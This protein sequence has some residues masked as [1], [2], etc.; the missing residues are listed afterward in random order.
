M[1]VVVVGDIDPAAM[2]KRIQKYF[3]SIQG[4]QKPK[5][6]AQYSV[7]DHDETLVAIAKDKEFPF[8]NMSVMW[9]HQRAATLT[10]AD[11]RRDLTHSL[12]SAMINARMS[13]LVNSS[14]PPFLGGSAGYGGFLG[15]KDVYSVDV[16]PDPQ[17]PLEALKAALIENRRVQLHGFTEGEL[18][19]AKKELMARYE[20][21]YNE[22]KKMPSAS[23][24][25][26][27]VNHFLKGDIPVS[28]ADRFEMASKML[29][30][31]SLTEVNALTK[32]YIRDKS[33]I[34]VLQAPDKDGIT[35]PSK[36]D[37]LKILDETDGL[38]PE[39]YQDKEIA[40]TLIEKIPKAGK[41]TSSKEL[42]LLKATEMT[43]SNGAKVVL[44]QTDFKEDEIQVSAI[45]R[46]GHS[47]YADKDYYSASWAD[48][49]I[50]NAGLGTLS[51]PDL[52]KFLSG[53]ILEGSP[54]IGTYSEG[55]N[56]GS[57]VKDFETL[58]QAMYLY[59]TSPRESET[60]FG[61]MMKRSK[62]TYQNLHTN[63]QYY[64][65][66]Q[67][68]RIL[69]PNSVRSGIPKAEDLDKIDYARAYQI[70]RERFA[71]ASDFTFFI[72]GN[73]DM[74]KTKKLIETYIASL[75]AK[76]GNEQW[77]DLG[78]EAPKGMVTK[79]LR[80]GTEPKAVVSMV[81]HGKLKSYYK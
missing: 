69:S 29:G 24:V 72:V 43:L 61:N 38:T 31:I 45:S 77:K 13:E 81:F 33:R 26:K 46:G 68:S 34:I 65:Y 16:T 28:T 44:K 5:E 80:K 66:D 20:K 12:Y 49:I 7:P 39:P 57:S 30:Q 14:A 63:P 25:N 19:R 18:G 41:I 9:K 40:S 75:P 53:K 10:D 62:V 4:P 78:I 6:R 60:D 37:L 35:V 21:S 8:Y 11:F 67:K 54:Y 36:E 42:P 22:R 15:D 52:Q 17:K 76:A 2:E 51:T 73:F 55:M 27:Y 1:A 74:A 64:F 3:G 79:T 48:G 71:D 32:Q 70:Y 59:F 58:M 56:G 23:H 47:L 50:E